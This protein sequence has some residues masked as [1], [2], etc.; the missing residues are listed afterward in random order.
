MIAAAERGLSGEFDVVGPFVTFDE[1]DEMIAGMAP[2]RTSVAL[3]E[4]GL[5]FRPV[6]ETIL[7][8]LAWKRSRGRA[9]V[10]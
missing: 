9:M 4:L 2:S 3:P 8:T 7:D 10:A 5:S 6:E 1:L